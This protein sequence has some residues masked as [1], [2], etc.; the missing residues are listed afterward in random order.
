LLGS[1]FPL[2]AHAAIGPGNGAGK[3]ISYLYL[4]N[5][6]GSTLGSFLIGFV[7]LN[8]WSTRTTS[9]ILFS[10][11][12]VTYLALVILSGTVGKK[13]IVIAGC[14]TC[15]LLMLCSGELYS[16]M[17]ERLL[18]KSDYTPG[19]QFSDLMENRSGL[20]AVM[21]DGTVFGGGVY[22]GRFNTDLIRDTNGI[23]RAFAIAGLH[24]KPTNVL[25]IGL[26]SGSWAQVVAN[27]N[28]VKNITIVEIN[29]G[30]LP[31][32]RKNREVESLLRNPKVH[33]VI[34][35][36]RRWLASHP[37]SKFDFILM[38]TTYNWRANATN[39]LSREFLGLI[40]PHLN[41]GGI[42][43]YNTTWSEEVM[44]TGLS[45]YPYSL[46]IANF[47]A[48]SDSPFTLDKKLWREALTNYQLDGHP[49]FDLSIPLHQKR[50]EEVLRIADE[51]DDPRSMHESR[52]GMLKRLA[53]VPIITDDNMGTEW[54]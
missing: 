48:V 2:L 23:F 7:V 31:L 10:L 44:A 40:R 6:I 45:V 37:D 20:I 9:T 17:Y 51:Q 30:Y 32:M 39:L 22:D 3:S 49:V 46:R 8:H 14:L 16:G 42:E 13:A 33:L 15:L 25:I 50:L 38:N 53:R 29:P 28:A 47:L 36:G 19:L 34:D 4:S 41:S 35:D 18:T 1:A 5:I 26:S 12:F 24:P 52:V 27:N 43:Y 21:Q 54:K 11:G